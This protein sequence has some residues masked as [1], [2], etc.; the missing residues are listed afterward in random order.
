V[1]PDGTL[2]AL[3]EQPSGG[4]NPCHVSQDATGRHLFVANYADG[5]IAAFDVGPDGLIGQRT[6]LKRFSG[7]GPNPRQA[8]PHAHSVYVSPENTVVYSCDLGSDNVWIFRFDAFDGGLAPATPPS[9]KVPPGSGPRHLAFHPNGKFVYVDGEMGHNVT[10]FTRDAGSGALTALET[11]P[12][13]PGGTPGDGI[14]TAEVACHPSG[15]WLYV[16]NRTIDTITVFKIGDDGR[17]SLV[18]STSSVA[19]FPRDFTIDPT[20]QWLLSAGQND[21]RIAVLKIDQAT[22]LLADTGQSA[23]VVAPVCILFVPQK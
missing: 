16:S 20:G 21:N 23:V 9:A 6:A 12:T 22:G 4:G 5:T 17:L 18:Q 13:L 19:K 15:K 10:V 1:R 8:R 3:N 7:S 2:I 11:V 14:T